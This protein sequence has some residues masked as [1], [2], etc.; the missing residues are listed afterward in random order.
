MKKLKSVLDSYGP[1][2]IDLKQRDNYSFVEFYD[3]TISDRVISELD[4]TDLQG[5][6][7]HKLCKIS[8]KREVRNQRFFTF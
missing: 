6:N 3:Q 8:Y 5:V 2:Y 4:N 7:N 1:N